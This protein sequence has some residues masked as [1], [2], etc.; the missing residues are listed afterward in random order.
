MP[1]TTPSRT[2]RALLLDILEGLVPGYRVFTRFGFNDDTLPTFV[3]I[4]I[5]GGVR[6]LPAAAGIVS[7]S[8]TSVND[9]AVTGSGARTLSVTGLDANFVEQEDEVA[10]NGLTPVVTTKSFLRIFDLRVLTAGATGSNEGDITASIGGDNQSQIRIGFNVSKDVGFTVPA[11]HVA[12]L[13]DIT[14]GV[15]ANKEVEL[16]FLQRP[17]GGVFYAEGAGF[18]FQNALPKPVNFAVGFPEKTDINVQGRNNSTAPNPETSVDYTMV[19]VEYRDGL[20][21]GFS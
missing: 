3:D 2:D 6:T 9:I 7:I 11:N 20:P 21:P 10:L 15:G 13:S 1:P 18:V 4:S 16:R 8:S 14:F 19:V 5:L 12:Y 17:F